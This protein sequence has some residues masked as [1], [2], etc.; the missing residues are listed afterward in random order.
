MSID[1]S[2][3]STWTGARQTMSS[4]ARVIESFEAVPD[5]FKEACKPILG[6]KSA[7]P[8]AVFCPSVSGFPHKTIEKVICD[9]EDVLYIWERT[10]KLITETQYAWKDISDLEAGSILLFSWLT[11]SGVTRA[12]T[13]CA[14]TVEFNT[15]TGRH[16]AHFVNKLR[17]ASMPVDAP[18]K[19]TERAKFD[20]LA[21]ENFKFMNYGAE[22]L[23]GAEKVLQTVWQPE[24]KRPF[25]LWWYTFWRTQYL[26]HL[27]ILTDKELILVQDDERSLEIRGS[28]HGGKWRY[29]P[30]A[31]IK[32]AVTSEREDGLLSLS[33]T[34]VPGEGRL[35]IPFEASHTQEVA[36]MCRQLEG[37]ISLN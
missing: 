26:P 7:L 30:L 8:Y 34:L 21:Q 37:K 23:S 6:D 27:T 4:W 22:S 2:Q 29:V 19:K 25:T 24:I 5:A 16:L 1:H 17:P 15:V 33:L 36:Q 18:M 32:T 9:F 12:G 28:R 10:G 13:S 14:S 11:F 20:Y 3:M 31:H 35:D